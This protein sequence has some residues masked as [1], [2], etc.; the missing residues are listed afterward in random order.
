MP[1]L[2]WWAIA[3]VA[4]RASATLTLLSIFLLGAWLNLKGLATVGE[5]VTFMNF[6]TMLIA[7][8]E[9]VVGFAYVASG[10][11]VRSSYKAGEFWTES[12]LRK[13]RGEAP[14]VHHAA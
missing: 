14:P 12:R 9:Q 4:T 1:V 5:I 7:R 13:Q 2:S 11:L 3:A 6:A 8:L 10:P